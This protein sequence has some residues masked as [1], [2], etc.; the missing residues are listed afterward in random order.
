MLIARCSWSNSSSRLSFCYFLYFLFLRWNQMVRI[1]VLP[2][3][4]RLE[5]KIQL[6]KVSL[7]IRWPRQ[8]SKWNRKAPKI[9]ACRGGGLLHI[10][11]WRNHQ[12]QTKYSWSWVSVRVSDCGRD[13][14]AL[15][16]VLQVFLWEFWVTCGAVESLRHENSLGTS[17]AILSRQVGAI[18]RFPIVFLEFVPVLCA[19]SVKQS[20]LD[21][22]LYS[23]QSGCF[24][25]RT[26]GNRHLLQN[27]R[28][29]AQIP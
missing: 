12:R 22:V 8:S 13:W 15:V 10:R 25:L 4:C 17:G 27:I 7:L 5:Y 20:S 26:R 14:T 29:V 28:R 2:L 21:R 11:K 23:A 16:V 24:L 6:L 18:N 19:L 3:L 1:I 9:V